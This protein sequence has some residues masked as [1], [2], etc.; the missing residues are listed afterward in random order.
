MRPRGDTLISA[1][2]ARAVAVVQMA[3]GHWSFAP[4]SAPGL[5]TTA[6]L[7]DDWLL[8]DAAV[9]EF[10]AGM[11]P[12][13]AFAANALLPSGLKW[14]TGPSDGTLRLRAELPVLEQLSIV[15]A[16]QEVCAGLAAAVELLVPAVAAQ[17]E[18]ARRPQSAIRNPQW[19]AGATAAEVDLQQLCAET[20][21]PLTLRGPAT[22]MIELDVP[23]AFQQAVVELQPGRGLVASLP[24]V[25]ELPRS[26]VCAAAVGV[27]LLRITGAVRMVR[28]AM[29][30]SD[31]FV[32]FEV[33]R[34]AT[35]A[36][37]ELAE[38]FAA[39]S[40]AWRCAGREA[41]VLAGDELVARLYLDRAPPR[42]T[43]KGVFALTTNNQQPDS[44][45]VQ[46]RGTKWH[47]QLQ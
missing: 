10:A 22:V 42:I 16:V 3:P 31:G 40:V 12:W 30:A 15:G 14:C 35:P 37:A 2:E 38:G 39:L 41:A 25:S 29:R 33:V 17:R 6:K 19:V 32:C 7:T 4:A 44:E 18:A 13:E 27:F 20:T 5:R 8:V 23:G 47:K 11:S 46:R 36:P 24:V 45:A 34:A 21:W 1:L 43:S 9:P 28:A 26:P